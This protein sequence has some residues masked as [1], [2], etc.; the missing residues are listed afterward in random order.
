MSAIK[1]PEK[2]Q[3]M[4]GKI[5]NHYDFTNGILSFQ[6]HHLWNRQLFRSL[7]AENTLLD[8]CS[9]TGE[10]AYR[11][12]DH[13]DT[14]KTAIFLDF[15]EEMLEGAKA[16]RLPHLIK[17]HH[18][19]FIQADATFLPIENESVDAV[20]VAYGIRN[21]QK[22]EKCFSE[23]L[24]VLKPSGK[25]SI[26]ELTEPSNPILKFFHNIYLTK[27]LPYL[28]GFLTREKEAY[29]YLAQSIPNFSK[30]DELKAQLLSS[31]FKKVD[32]R[33]LTGGIATLIEAHKP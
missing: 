1:D 29:T 28:G 8:L 12:L 18:L 7:K 4:F 30:P 10:I 22:P 23:V 5:A 9:G 21:V 25:L 17:G 6:L 14:P 16:K 20:S 3:T 32:I 27:I 13:Q 26:L 15:C 11:W 31:G 33:S 24:R 2:I 19:R